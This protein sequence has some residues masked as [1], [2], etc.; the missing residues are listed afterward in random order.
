MRNDE[1]KDAVR[2]ITAEL[3]DLAEVAAAEADAVVANARR[4]LAREG[5]DA[6][7]RLGSLVGDLET[8][9]SRTA[10]VVD[11]TRTRLS[12]T[13]P[14]GATRL[15]SLHDPDARP[16]AKGRLGKPVEFGYKAQVIDNAD[17]IVL[18]YKVTV[19]NPP[20]AGLLAPAIRRIKALL[21][22]VPRAVTADRG[23]GEA[24]VDA[25]LEA[26]G[27]K[28]VVIPRKGKPSAARR[29]VEHRRGFRNLIKWRTGCEGRI[30]HLKHGG[31]WDCTL[32]DGIGGAETWCGL[33]ILV[34]NSVK[35]ARLIDAK[36]LAKAA[37][38]AKPRVPDRAATGPPPG[39][40]ALVEA[41]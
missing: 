23:Y 16:I 19:G 24:A 17:G 21:G 18:D 30:S 25:E 33:G 39:P 22:K 27:V 5:R 4:K 34:Q 36:A 37:S 6:S 31:G 38:A 2:A 15:V 9:L 3:A 32:L 10:Q 40:P 20:D 28:K 12:G 29:Q 13:T 26:L 14:D 8:L 11:Q 35:I 1:A 7:A 41:C